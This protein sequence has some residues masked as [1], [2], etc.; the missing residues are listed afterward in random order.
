[1]TPTFVQTFRFWRRWPWSLPPS[2]IWCHV[3]W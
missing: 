3:F 2:G 1:M